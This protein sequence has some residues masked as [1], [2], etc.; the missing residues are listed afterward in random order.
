[1][2]VDYQRAAETAR[3]GPKEDAGEDTEINFY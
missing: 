2:D 3:N 1:M